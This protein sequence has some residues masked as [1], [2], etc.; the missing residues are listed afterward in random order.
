MKST[1]RSIRPQLRLPGLMARGFATFKSKKSF[2]YKQKILQKFFVGRKPRGL[3]YEQVVIPTPSQPKLRLC[4]V[5]AKH[6]KENAVGLLWLHGGGYAMGTPEQSMGFIRLF[7][8]TGQCVVVAP[9]YTLSLDA[10]YPAALQDG[11][12]ALE[13][14]ARHADTLGIRPDQLFLGGESAGGGLAAAVSLLARDK[15]Q[16]SI[17]FQM[18]LYPMLDDRRNTPSAQNNRTPGWDS[19]ANEIAWRLY[20]GDLFGSAH[21]PAY[22]TPARAES[23]AGLPPTYT[24]V[25]DIEPFYDETLRFVAALQAAGVE[26]QADVYAG[27]FHGFDIIAPGSSVARQARKALLTRFLWAVEHCKREQPKDFYPFDPSAPSAP[28]IPSGPSNSS[29]G[30]P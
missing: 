17:A 11:Y 9:D 8:Q 26:A 12:A 25:G 19:R 20:L 27:C 29:C 4:V 21:V 16:P 28:S 7:A 1:W 30:C 13:W 6:C 23:L 5:K 22:A 24:Y 15:G 10:P 14:M 18:P 2:A 3:L